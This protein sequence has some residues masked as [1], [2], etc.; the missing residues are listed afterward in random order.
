MV[1]GTAGEAWS[2]HSQET[3]VCVIVSDTVAVE[4]ARLSREG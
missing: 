1:Q 2:K 3:E 4:P